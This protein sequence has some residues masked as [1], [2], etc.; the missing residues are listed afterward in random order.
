MTIHLHHVIPLFANWLNY[1]W[2]K[3]PLEEARHQLLH[4]MRDL[5]YKQYSKMIR[6]QREATSWHLVMTE[7]WL[8]IMQ[9]MQRYFFE[10]KNLPQDIMEKENEVLVETVK[11][12]NNIYNKI[13][14]EQYII[15]DFTNPLECKI[16]V[17]LETHR[18]ILKTLRANYIL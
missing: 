5:P 7:K 16:G 14:G 2:C 4:S 13:T 18:E 15:E 6:K 10:N 9:E 1:D 17:E 3:I 12:W 8:L 11:Y